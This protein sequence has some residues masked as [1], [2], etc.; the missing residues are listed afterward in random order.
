[1][2]VAD[3]TIFNSSL[4]IRFEYSSFVSGDVWHAFSNSLKYFFPT[5]VIPV[6]SDV[7]DEVYKE[8]VV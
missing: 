1:M 6:L 7:L 8:F 5:A 4:S 3:I 2:S